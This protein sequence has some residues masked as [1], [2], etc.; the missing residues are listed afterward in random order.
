MTISEFLIEDISCR[1]FDGCNFLFW[2]RTVIDAMKLIGPETDSNLERMSKL[3]LDYH[4]G[5][6]VTPEEVDGIGRKI[7]L[8]RGVGYWRDDSPIGLK[9][10]CIIAIASSREENLNDL[11][12][13][14][15]GIV[16]AF[17][18]INLHDDKDQALI[19]LIR[20]NASKYGVNLYEKNDK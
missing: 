15:Y 4:A 20:E 10:R 12:Y 14:Q 13:W 1:A 8:L 11:Y 16:T 19:S 2:V 6:D 5:T 9:Y 3:L 18:L 7:A 17:D